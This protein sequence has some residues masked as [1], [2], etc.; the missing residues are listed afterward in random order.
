MK[1]Q[2]H[3]VSC[4]I[5]VLFLVTCTSNPQ[6]NVTELENKGSVM[7]V[8]APEWVQLYLKK[9]LSAVQAQKEYQDK[10]CIIGEESGA[11]RQFVLAWADAASAQQRIG[12]FLRTNIASRYEAAITATAQTGAGSSTQFR[13]E[14]DNI[15]NAV[16]NISFSGAQRE[17]DWWSLRRRYDTGNREVYA[18]EYTAYVLYTIP[19]EEMNRQLAFALETS[20]SKDSALYDITITLARDILL[21]GYE[22]GVVQTTAVIQQSAGDFYDP[23]G[24]VVTRALNE[25]NPID[26]YAVGRDVAAAILAEYSLWNG[27]PALT[28]YVNR[29]CAAIV[30]NSPRPAGYNGYHIAIL[31]SDTINAFATPGGHIFV[32]RG[33][34]SAARSEDALASVIAH[35]IAHIQLRHGLRSIKTGHDT[36]EWFRQFSFSGAQIIAGSLNTG[37]SQTQEFDADIS[38]ISLLAATGYSPLGLVDMLQELEKIQSGRAG[39]FNATHPSPTSRLVNA[40]VAAARYA[41]TTDNRAVRQRRFNAVSAK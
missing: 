18:D 24:S 15:L 23:P 12:A 21:Q 22:E 29:I 40:K 20:A 33:L 1:N 16:V 25:I 14:I 6:S 13:Q 4:L 30:I 17:A 39:G 26:E 27:A 35:E 11:N 3:V 31:D 7:G 9:G 34:V 5:C 2:R 38:A 36:A 8:L 28:N 19:K 41:N 32:T 10:Y 37:F